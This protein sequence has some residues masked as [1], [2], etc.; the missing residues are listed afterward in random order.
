M[1][2]VNH[3]NQIALKLIYE[4]GSLKCNDEWLFKSSLVTLCLVC[5][6]LSSFWLVYL[7]ISLD[8]YLFTLKIMINISEI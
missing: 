6:I 1:D 4:G 5:L 2:T 7:I 3:M 8:I